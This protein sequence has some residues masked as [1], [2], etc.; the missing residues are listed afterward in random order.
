V[1]LV[2]QLLAAAAVEIIRKQVL[3]NLVVLVA[4]V[5]VVMLHL[6]QRVLEQQVKE[7]AEVREIQAHQIMVL[8]EVVV[9]VE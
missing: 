9:L 5:R 2:Q 7:I 6:M 8:V 1:R 3:E 4:E